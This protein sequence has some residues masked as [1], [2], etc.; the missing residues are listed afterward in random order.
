MDKLLSGMAEN[1]GKFGAL[2]FSV[3]GLAIWPWLALPVVLVAIPLLLIRPVDM[4]RSTQVARGIF[5][6]LPAFWLAV[7]AIVVIFA[8]NDKF[9]SYLIS[10]IAVWVFIGL[11]FVMMLSG[12]A[13][14]VMIRGWHRLTGLALLV[15]N[16]WI[17]VFCAFFGAMLVS[18][19]FL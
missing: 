11:I 7:C 6:A 5:A 8:A 14:I 17:I 2:L 10:Q 13:A 16:L 15:V 12:V 3:E 9:D 4:P 1:I 18:G 19:V